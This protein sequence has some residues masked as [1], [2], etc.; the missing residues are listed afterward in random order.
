V[1]IATKMIMTAVRTPARETAEETEETHAKEKNQVEGRR[2]TPWRE[3]RG[4]GATY[5]RQSQSGWW[6]HH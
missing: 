5:Q 4:G 6:C 3:E 2:R 1:K